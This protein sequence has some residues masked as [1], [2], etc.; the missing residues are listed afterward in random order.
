MPKKIVLDLETKKT[1]DEVGGYHN[2]AQLGVSLVGVYDYDTDSYRVYKEEEFDQLL[3]LLQN[4]DLV[5]GFNSKKFDFTVLSPYF[6]GVDL[7][8]IPHLDILEEVHQT[9]GFRLKLDAIAHATLHEG[10]SGSGLDAIQFYRKGDWK[11]LERYCLDDVRVTK[12]VHE[13]G[14]RHGHIWY[15]EA[16]RLQR[17]KVSWGEHPFVSEIIQQ[18][19]DSHKQL[20]VD[21]IA[22]DNKEGKTQKKQCA[23]DVRS[24]EGDKIRAFCH[25]E[26]KVRMF[27]VPKIFSAT[28]VGEMDSVQRRL[29]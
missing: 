1:F 29:I 2:T 26:N 4:T 8:K 25:V 20:E 23:I 21:Y 16:G 15:P 13:Y 3:R 14:R 6:K 10:K 5:I 18:A 9:L 27:E 11:S 12:D 17:L 7:T 19:L 24:I 28:I 22:V